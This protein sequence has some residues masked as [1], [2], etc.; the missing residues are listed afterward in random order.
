M[1][2]STKKEKAAHE[3]DEKVINEMRNGE[4]YLKA[5][6][7]REQI[8]TKKKWGRREAWHDAT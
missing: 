8:K 3:C 5:L 1:T 6:K 4:G 7:A 2:P